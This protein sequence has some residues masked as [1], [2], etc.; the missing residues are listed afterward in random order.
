MAVS[1]AYLHEFSEPLGYLDFAAV[2]PPSRRVQSAVANAYAR[3][4]EPEGSIGPA[5]L[6]TYEAALGTVGRFVGVAPELATVVPS[7]SSGLF[8]VAFGLAPF[9]G[10]I[11]VPSHEFPANIYPWLR[12]A[13]MG[14]PEVRLVDVPDRRVTAGALSDAVDD[15]TRAIAVS[16]VDY[17]SGFRP[18][19]V[20]LRELADDGLLI[21][22]AIQG[23]GA[24][25]FSAAPADVV[26][27]GGQKWLR[28]GFGSGVLALSP[29]S[30][31]MLHPTLTGWWGVEDSFDWEVPPPHKARGDAEQFQDGGPPLFGAFA[32][33]AAVEVI[34]AEGIGVIHETI[35]DNVRALEDVVRAAGGTI[36]EPW[37][38]EDERSGILSFRL[39]EESATTT[40]HR[41]AEADVVASLRGEWVR[42]APHASTDVAVTEVLAEV[43]DAGAGAS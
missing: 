31:E 34:D 22:D 36:L 5:V 3:V 39:R 29:R 33:A 8:R 38:T 25:D 10:N 11:V 35:M 12:A 28:A 2:G 9:G 43:L 24:M 7:T 17:L 21:V 23:L 42:L 41:L 1:D 14:G 40:S 15:E 26:I 18:N 37:E 16:S 4:A 19:L 6:G 27:A 13:G 32:L 30:I 20:A